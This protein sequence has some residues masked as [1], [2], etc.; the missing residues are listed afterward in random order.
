MDCSGN[1]RR[2]SWQLP[3]IAVEIAVVITADCHGVWKSQWQLPRMAAKCRGLPSK[4]P[5]QFL[6]LFS[7]EISASIAAEIA[8]VIATDRRGMP[9]FSAEIA[10]D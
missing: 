10:V 5:W 8:V 7:V 9:W 1:C 2:L 6:S 4:S 3:L